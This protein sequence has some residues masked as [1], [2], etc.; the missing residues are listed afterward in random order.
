[1]LSNSF[2]AIKLQKIDIY[3]KIQKI[4]N[5]NEVPKNDYVWKDRGKDQVT[6]LNTSLLYINMCTSLQ[7]PYICIA[8]VG[9]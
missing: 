9:I 8:L 5:I 7:N 4:I 1:M 3:L 6:L 2:F